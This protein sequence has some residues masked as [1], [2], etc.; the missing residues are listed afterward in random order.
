MTRNVA[1]LSES[2]RQLA[3]I[4]RAGRQ[5]TVAGKRKTRAFVFDDPVNDPL[6]AALDKDVSDH[7]AQFKALRD[8]KQMVLALGR[9]VFDEVV[10]RQLLRMNQHRS[11]DL[12]GIVECQRTNHLRRSAFHICEMLGKLCARLDLDVGGELLEHV[13]EQR[14]LVV[15]IAARTRRKQ[16]GDALKDPQALVDAADRR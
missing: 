1:A 3:I 2:Q 6:I 4:A 9:G 15:R 5:L 8:R 14:D 13:I 10:I 7:L 11:R 12:D 16:I